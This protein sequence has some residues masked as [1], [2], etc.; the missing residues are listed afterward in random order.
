MKKKSSE[1]C[2]SC[3]DN[4]FITKT[5]QSSIYIGFLCVLK[6][7]G[8][9]HSFDFFQDYTW[10]KVVSANNVSKQVLYNSPMPF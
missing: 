2:N 3:T 4:N 5:V 7:A 8:R 10:L 6:F 1:I 9:L